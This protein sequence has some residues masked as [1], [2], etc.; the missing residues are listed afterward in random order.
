MTPLAHDEAA[1]ALARLDADLVIAASGAEG[2]LDL[3]VM[4]RR[5]IAAYRSALT[6]AAGEPFDSR[7][8]VL[9]L[10]VASYVASLAV[11]LRSRDAE[12]A[13]ARLCLL[14]LELLPEVLELGG[15]LRRERRVVQV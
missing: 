1:G 15:N 9:A 13:V 8:N 5:V 6:E 4:R 7:W 10:T 2:A 11:G 3:Q 14:R 12:A